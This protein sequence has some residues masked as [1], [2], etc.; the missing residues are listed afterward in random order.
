MKEG[1]MSV[2]IRRGVVAGVAAA[3][4]VAVP[5]AALA[6]GSLSGK[7]APS[8][9]AASKSVAAASKSVAAG[10]EPRVD[11]S[12]AAAK[13]SAAAASE[14]SLDRSWTGPVAVAALASRLGVS[15]GAALRVL[16]QIGTLSGQ[17]GV[18]PTDPA[19]VAIARGLGV[20]PDRLA[21]GLGGVKQA[22]AGK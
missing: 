22:L 6:S 15:H 20:S 19:F 12:V 2:R 16:R 18:D 8:P 3:A 10:S 4:A 1:V 14:P 11:P 13:K 7:P 17:G 5:A 21:A 9:S